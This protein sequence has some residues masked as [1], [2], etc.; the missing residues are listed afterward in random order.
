MIVVLAG[1]V[2]AARFLQGLVQIV[3]PKDLYVIVNTADDF[4]QHGLSISPDLDI[5]MYTLSG[6][7]DETQGWGIKNDTINCLE[8]LKRYKQDT[9]FK[10]GDKDLAT[11]IYRT[12]LLKSGLTLSEITKILCLNLGV[13]VNLIPMTDQKVA[14]KIKIP[15]G[16]IHFEEF[17]IKRKAQDKVLEIIYEGAEDAK[18]TD[19][20]LDIIKDA[21][22]ILI[23][24]SNPLVSI[25]TILSIKQ[26]RKALK[27]ANKPIVGIS[28]IIGNKPVKGPL[29][30]LMKGLGMEVSCVGVAKFYKNLIKTFI[31]DEIDRDRKNQIEELGIK[32]LVTNT[33]MKNLEI[34]K[35]LA[36]I[37]LDAMNN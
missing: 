3:N 4:E 35:N 19:G 34:K 15:T 32:V 24:P 33:L 25:N 26:I 1:G 2:G 14:T 31:I 29:D 22:G 18:P 10:L 11:H 6:I 36:Q 9:W 28:P 7:V 17:M 21:E 27:Q 37:T 5:I 30:T 8:M 16:T 12:Q 23:G 13:K 20:I